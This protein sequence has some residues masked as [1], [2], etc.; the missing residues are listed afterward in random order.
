MPALKCEICHSEEGVGQES[1]HGAPSGYLCSP[2][3]DAIVQLGNT[4]ETLYR[5][6]M[7]LDGENINE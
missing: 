5:V 3:S 7:Y 1:R 2:C 6:A 4:T